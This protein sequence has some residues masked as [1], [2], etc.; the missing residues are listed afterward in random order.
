MAKM[1]KTN[2]QTILHMTQQRKLKKKQHK[3]W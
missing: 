1:K 3:L 2:R